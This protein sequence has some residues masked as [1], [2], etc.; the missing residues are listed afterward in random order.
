[1]HAF[2]EASAAAANLPELLLRLV[3][4][5]VTGMSGK[6]RGPPDRRYLEVH[7]SNLIF[8]KPG[9]D[10]E[11]KYVNETLVRTTTLWEGAR[12]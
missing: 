12:K 4:D 10:K 8:M 9:E 2:W 6:M 11:D 3:S 1:M 7:E 5:T